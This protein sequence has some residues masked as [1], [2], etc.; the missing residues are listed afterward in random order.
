M[1]IMSFIKR[2]NT[3][4]MTIIS[5]R[6]VDNH[7]CVYVNGLSHFTCNTSIGD[8]CHFNGLVVYGDGRVTI[9]NHFHSGKGCV[10]LTQ[11]HDFESGNQLPYGDNYIM[12]DVIIDENVWLGI[13]VTI[14]PGVHIGEGAI[15][16]AGSVV[17]SDIPPLAIAGGHPARIFNK[18]D[19]EHYYKVKATQHSIID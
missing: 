14:L 9:G 8:D 12:K 13:N 11:N 5:L 18:R 4:L 15:I 2:V 17:V 6:N 16:Q 3:A 10:I 1:D 7:G 19:S